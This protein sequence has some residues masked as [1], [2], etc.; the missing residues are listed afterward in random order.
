MKYPR[1]F[2]LLCSVTSAAHAAEPT[3]EIFSYTGK[4]LFPSA[5]ISTATVDWSEFEA[6]E[7]EEDADASDEAEAE[8]AEM[9][10]PRLAIPMAGL[11]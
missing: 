7:D 9:R 11:G 3:F 5:I 10:P 8:A 4:D 1:S 2:L 6:T